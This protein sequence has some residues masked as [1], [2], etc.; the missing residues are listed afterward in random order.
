MK[1][2]TTL[3]LDNKDLGFL[4]S[5]GLLADDATAGGHLVGLLGLRGAEVEVTLVSGDRTPSGGRATDLCDD[6]A[7][8]AL[9]EDR[10]RV[11]LGRAESIVG[12]E[13]T[14]VQQLHVLRGL[15]GDCC[16]GSGDGGSSG[17]SR[18][19]RSDIGV[20]VSRVLARGA[21]SHVAMVRGATRVSANFVAVLLSGSAPLA[22]RSLGGACAVRVDLGVVGS[23]RLLLG[24]GLSL[25]P[26]LLAR[27]APVAASAV[28]S[29]GGAPGE[30]AD[31]LA[32]T[33]R[34]D[35]AAVNVSIL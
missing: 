8:L 15:V 5:V 11:A 24:T 4:M 33:G 26:R 23:V 30:E 10:R 21:G 9:E 34:L 7:V 12:A 28:R 18:R 25:L 22:G 6:G 19:Q 29:V 14:G 13:D 3:L 1:K 27:F 32:S 35:G 17:S 16:G 2:Q 20:I 31:A